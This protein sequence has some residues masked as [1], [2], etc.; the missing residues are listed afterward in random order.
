MYLFKR[1]QWIIYYLYSSY[2][3][4]NTWID[5]NGENITKNISHIL[6]F[7]DKARFMA[8]S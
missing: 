3:K 8:G 6:Q 4:R 1:K 5:K 7:I 2:R